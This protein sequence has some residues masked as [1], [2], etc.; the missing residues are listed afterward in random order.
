MA[1][2]GLSLKSLELTALYLGI[3][4]YCSVLMTDEWW[5]LFLHEVPIL[6]A[7]LWI[8]YMIRFEVRSSYMEGKDNFPICGAMSSA[9]CSH[10]PIHR[11]LHFEQ[12]FVGFLRKVYLKAVSALPQLWIIH[13]TKI[14]EPYK[15]Y[16]VVSL[17]IAPFI[18][19]ANCVNQVLMPRGDLAWGTICGPL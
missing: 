5:V 16:N 18:I 4:V 19:I 15:A 9:I 1:W 6:M 2:L 11:A 17:G 10:S 7:T 12:N 8:I 13:N 3:K 14:V